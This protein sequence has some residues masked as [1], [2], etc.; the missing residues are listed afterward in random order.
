M[1]I[2]KDSPASIVNRLAAMEFGDVFNP[3]RDHCAHH[4]L[5]DAPIIRSRNLELTLVGAAGQ[6]DEM[7][8]ALEPGHRGARRTGLAMTDDQRLSEHAEYW[9]IDGIQR[10][11]K[12][13][14]ETEATAGTVW[15]A[16]KKKGSSIFLWNAFPLHTH[17][18]GIP[19]SNRRHTPAEREA[20]ATV[21]LAIFELV[22]PRR[23]FAIGRE[24]QQALSALGIDADYVRHPSYGGKAKFLE[25]I[26]AQ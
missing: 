25:G 7:W 3:Y 4:D 20:C 11:T 10:A 19:L 18:S 21:T 9:E 13:G 15:E 26:G 5:P 14:P 24:A 17:Q 1:K 6:V 12:S 8:F 16:L 2:P 22:R 23:V